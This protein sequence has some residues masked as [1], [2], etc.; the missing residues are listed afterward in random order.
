MVKY[1]SCIDNY[2]NALVSSVDDAQ[3]VRLLDDVIQFSNALI[4]NQTTW[5]FLNSPLMS[6]GEKVS[7]L[8]SFSKRLSIN[9]AVVNLFSLLIKNGRL[10]IL[11]ELIRA[12]QERKDVI[13]QVSNI[14]VVSAT[15][16]SEDQLSA[17]KIKLKETG[18]QNINLSSKN[19][20]SLI[21]GFKLLTKNNVYDLTLKSVFDEFKEKIK[22]N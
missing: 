18:H 12:C 1:K 7:F 11:S 14:E 15:P 9:K 16:F 13:N 4:S 10:V 22:R 19:D 17:L 2:L 8:D 6:S 5:V 21:S 3:K 20:P